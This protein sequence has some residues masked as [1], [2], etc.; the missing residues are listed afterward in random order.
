MNNKKQMKKNKKKDDDSKKQITNTYN[1]VI[2]FWRFPIAEL[3]NLLCCWQE[4]T[5]TCPWA[6]RR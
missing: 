4:L 6:F 3:D 5:T 2:R 1:F